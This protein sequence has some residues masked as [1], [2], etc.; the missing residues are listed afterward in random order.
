[1]DAKGGPNV[2]LIPPTDRPPGRQAAAFSL[3]LARETGGW[4]TANM[5]GGLPETI[6]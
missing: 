3:E 5:L 2:M 1:M 6:L 4:F